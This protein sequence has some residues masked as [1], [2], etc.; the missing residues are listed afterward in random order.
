M[1]MTDAA[2]L[3]SVTWTADVGDTVADLA[4]SPVDGQLAVGCSGGEVFAFDDAGAV[5]DRRLRH[6]AGTVCLTWFDGL[7]ASGGAD[8]W[9]DV[10]SQRHRVG[11]WVSDLAPGP[12]GLG[13][14]HGR[15]VSV[16]G[17]QT[18][19]PLPASV[20]HV[21]WLTDG[22]CG[23]V[24]LVACGHG[25][26]REFAPGLSTRGDAK[27]VWGGSVEHI[28]WSHDGRW[29]AA[30]TR[31]TTNYLWPRPVDGDRAGRVVD[32][33]AHV[34]VLPC[35]SGGGRLMSF[36]PTARYLGVA[37]NGGLAVFDLDEVHPVTGPS[38]RLLPLFCRANAFTWWP[39]APV[40]V[41]GVATEAGGGGLLLVRCDDRAAPV[42][43]VDLDAPVTCIAW[44]HR[45]DRLAVACDNGVVTVLE[46]DPGWDWSALD[47]RWDATDQ[48]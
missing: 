7:V 45:G 37:T 42:G 32:P 35:P 8:G 33:R 29:A 34:H 23:T 48:L 44:S 5:V 9:V 14:A 2:G 31:G 27:L 16:L 17:S 13:V 22:D 26:V 11:G 3:G 20:A 39:H 38:G 30:S 47:G 40:A 4:W 46:R 21:R 10:G 12:D 1:T 15:N 36:D 18:S 28:D 25:Y 43:V 24:G 6:P 19:G 41:L